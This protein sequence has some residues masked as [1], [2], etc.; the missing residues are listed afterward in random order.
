MVQQG[1][2]RCLFC[3]RPEEAKVVRHIAEHSLGVAIYPQKKEPF[4]R[5]GEWKDVIKPLLPGYVFVYSQEPYPVQRLLRIDGVLRCLT[6]GPEDKEGYLTGKDRQ[7]ALW[8][9]ENNG[10]ADKLQAIQEGSYVRIIDGLLKD[11]NGKVERVKKQKR[12]VYV[13]LKMAGTP[14]HVW[15]GYECLASE[16]PLPET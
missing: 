4:Y 8:L 15:M 10:V 14:L 12:M 9:L 2:V 6:Y 5:Q 11:Y 3:R 13:S 7:F 16:Q 1:L